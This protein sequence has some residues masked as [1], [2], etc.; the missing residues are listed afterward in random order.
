MTRIGRVRTLALGLTLIVAVACTSQYRNHGYIPSDDDLAEV[1]VGVDNRD[2]VSESIG[3]PTS[4]GIL[5]ESGYYYVRTRVRHF[6][7]RRPEMIERQL[8]AITFNSRGTVQNIERFSLQDGLVVPL[9]RRVT[10]NGI[11][12][13]NFLQSLIQSL[14]NFDAGSLLS[15]T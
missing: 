12:S 10:D 7:A 14:G 15:G 11:E 6:G 1:V 13:N 3:T 2:S 8:V 5:D 9:S 4:G